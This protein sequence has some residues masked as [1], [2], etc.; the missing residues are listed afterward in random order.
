MKRIMTGV[1]AVLL[2][3]GSAG[4][5]TKGYVRTQV[6]AAAD[7]S[8]IGWTAGDNTVRQELGQVRTDV[9]TL[10]SNVS[11]LRQ[12]LTVMR[13]SLGARIIAMEDGLK[14]IF[15]V[16]FASGGGA[17]AGA[18]GSAAGSG[19]SSGVSAAAPP[20]PP[21]SAATAKKRLQGLRQRPTRRAMNA[22]R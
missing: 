16:T 3:M 4:C 1:V 6:Q 19:A 18:G 20:Q 2:L 7:T 11:T 8:R 21:V 13:D 22:R 9:D 5:A 12:D 10:K 14:F 17:G 15:P